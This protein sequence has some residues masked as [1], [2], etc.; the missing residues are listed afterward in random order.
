M[1][2][3]SAIEGV[4]SSILAKRGIK[5]REWKGRKNMDGAQQHKPH[6]EENTEAAEGGAVRTYNIYTVDRISR[7]GHARNVAERKHVLPWFD[8]SL[9]SSGERI[10]VREGADCVT[11]K[12]RLS[13]IFREKNIAFVAS[14][15]ETSIQ[16]VFAT[17][18]P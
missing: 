14:P 7:T 18:F 5:G 6:E 17:F 8:E 9:A 12:S 15:V 3:P 13:F 1:V 11:T 4:R 2:I 16:Y 10:P